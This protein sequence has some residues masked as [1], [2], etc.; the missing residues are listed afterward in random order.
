MKQYYEEYWNRARPAPPGDPLAPERSRILWTLVDQAGLRPARLLEVGCGE[1]HV[2]AQATRRGIDS[3]GIDVADRAIERAK[4]LYPDCRFHVHSL[5]DRP[6]PADAASMDL[7]VAFEVIE[8]LLRPRQLLSGAADVLRPGGY[9]ALTTPYHGP[10]KNMMLA[11]SAFDRHFDVEGAHIRFFSDAAL[12]RLLTETG[13]EPL[14]VIH[15]GRFWPLWAG[16]FVWA[17]RSEQKR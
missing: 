11:L 5:E 1:G 15:F 8:H 14:L 12:R 10:A 6:W 2:V 16:A 3:V 4:A 17:R 9:L 13:F 7:L